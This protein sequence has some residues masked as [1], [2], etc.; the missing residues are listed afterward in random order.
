MNGNYAQV[1]WSDDLDVL[2]EPLTEL[3]KLQVSVSAVITAYNRADYLR[4]AL[5]SVLSQS[6]S[7]REVIVIDDCSDVDLRTVI[8]DFKVGATSHDYTG[9]IRYFRFDKNRGAN[10]ARNFGASMAQSE[11][12]AFLDDDDVWLSDKIHRQIA[13]LSKLQP[14]L[15]PIA[16]LCSYRFLSNGEVHAGPSTGVVSLNKLKRG[17]PY[18]GASGLIVK[19]DVVQE[20]RFDESLPCGQDW[21]AYVRLA[22]RGNIIYLSDALYLY[23]RGSH[24]GLTTKAKA[25]SIEEA[26]HRLASSFKHQEWLGPWHFRVRAAGQLLSYVFYKQDKFQWIRKSV[27]VAGPLAT[28][29]VLARKVLNK[30]RTLWSGG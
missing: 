7:V 24:E 29:F 2:D 11:W 4:Y 14:S 25:L 21:D 16:A 18:C 9:E 15:Q 17:N 20:Q 5:D 10:A 22:H 3:E 8:D 30:G 1:S 26:D 13:A 12:I 6:M 27:E 19:T 28:G 23:R